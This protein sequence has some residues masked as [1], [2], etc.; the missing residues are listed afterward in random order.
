MLYLIYKDLYEYTEIYKQ[1]DYDSRLGSY[2]YSGTNSDSGFSWIRVLV[3]PWLGPWKGISSCEN[4]CYFWLN[5]G[6]MLL[7]WSYPTHFHRFLNYKYKI[8]SLM[9]LALGVADVDDIQYF[10]TPA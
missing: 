3:S 7:I 6:W 10:L 2:I 4:P 5:L 9:F 8:V 1:L